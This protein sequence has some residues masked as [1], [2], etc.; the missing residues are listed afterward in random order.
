MLIYIEFLSFSEKILLRQDTF[1]FYGYTMELTVAVSGHSGL[2]YHNTTATVQQHSQWTAQHLLL[3]YQLPNGI[4]LLRLQSTLQT[5]H[6]YKL[7]PIE[8]GFYYPSDEG[9]TI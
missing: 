3:N 9:S 7:S 6:T 4:H 2:P 5:Q 8:E 1:N